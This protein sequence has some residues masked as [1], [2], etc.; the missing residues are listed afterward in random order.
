[1][2]NR[3]PRVTLEPYPFGYS[4]AISLIDD[5]DL[6]T[7]SHMKA[8]Y[9]YLSRKNIQC[10]RTVWPFKT[11]KLSGDYKCI[12]NTGITLQDKNYVK[13]CKDLQLDGFEIAMHTA[14]GGNSKRNETIDAYNYFMDC[15]EHPP[16]TNIMHGRNKENLYWGKSCVNNSIMQ[17]AISVL[18]PQD[19]GGHVKD[20]PYFWGDICK[21]HTLYVR[22]FETLQLNTSKF[23]Q[24]MPYHDPKKPFVNWWFSASYGEGI[25]FY[26]LLK[27]ENISNL[28]K[29]QGASVIHLYLRHYVQSNR[30]KHVVDKLFQNKIEELAS[31]KNIWFTPVYKLLNRIRAMR[32]IKI[33]Y[34]DSNVILHN[35]SDEDIN[36]VSLYAPPNVELYKKAN[37]KPFK[38]SINTEGKINIGEFKKNDS[39]TL[40]SDSPN[41]SII[42]SNILRKRAPQY[43]KLLSGYTK[44]LSWQFLNGRRSMTYGGNPPWA[45][46]LE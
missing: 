24:A 29:E 30:N 25:R 37:D 33:T 21:K 22:Q 45:E 9:Q 13:F 39:I 28:I 38:L 12:S 36:N 6:S 5:T 34:K 17:K 41:L 10:T 26:Q 3:Q 42:K 44:R 4:C 18:E 43:H 7:F 40:F 19:F 46:N 1:M 20:S 27:K 14:S 23:D 31:Y 15:F 32:D 2:L 8:M 11:S 35:C 16:Y